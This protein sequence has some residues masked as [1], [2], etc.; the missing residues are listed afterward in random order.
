MKRFLLLLLLL[1]A[2]ARADDSISAFQWNSAKGT[3]QALT[4]ALGWKD[5]ADTDNGTFGCTYAGTG[6]WSTSQTISFNYSRVGRT[7]TISSPAL[8][9]APAAA[10]PASNIAVTA[11]IPT[12]I[13][14]LT[15]VPYIPCIWTISAGVD[16][17]GAVGT[18]GF[19]ASGALNIF[20]STDKTNWG[21]SG[22]NGWNAFT[23]TYNM[24]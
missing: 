24:N 3:F 20:K 5:V 22:N 21:T 6:I 14:P 7:V 8:S 10:S 23:C 12:Q 9:A 1:A 13:R 17:T 18:I 4:R 2:P 16:Y 19:L 15:N 11:C